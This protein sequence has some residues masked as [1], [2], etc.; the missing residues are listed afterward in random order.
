M[1]LLLMESFVN[2]FAVVV[3]MLL[4]VQDH[5]LHHVLQDILRILKIMHMVKVYKNYVNKLVV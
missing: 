1:E 5:V 2:K 4:L 3:N